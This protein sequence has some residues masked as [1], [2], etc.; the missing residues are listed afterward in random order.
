ME[1]LQIPGWEYF[2]YSKG[3][4]QRFRERL[5]KSKVFD[6]KTEGEV[7]YEVK[8]EDFTVNEE[9]ENEEEEE[10]VKIEEKMQEYR[11]DEEYDFEEEERLQK[12]LEE[13]ER[14]EISSRTRLHTRKPKMKSEKLSSS[15]P[16]VSLFYEDDD[17]ELTKENEIEKLIA[18]EEQR[19]CR[20]QEERNVDDL[21]KESSML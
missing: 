3:W 11:S 4:Y 6:V 16:E 9:N 20:K 13:A 15:K 7:K 14:E 12:Q 2:N 1:E 18:I 10:D 17:D 8:I 19:L 5:S 21:T